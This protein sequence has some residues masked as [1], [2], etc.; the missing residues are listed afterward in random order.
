MDFIDFNEAIHFVNH[1]AKLAEKEEHHPDLHLT[2]YN[3]LE[4]KLT[5]HD[6]KGITNLDFV[7]AKRVNDLIAAEV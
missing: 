4:I 2:H 3:Q 1:L 6:E 5:T 7:F